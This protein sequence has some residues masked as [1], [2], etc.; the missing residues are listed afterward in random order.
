M[1]F[2]ILNKSPPFGAELIASASKMPTYK[3]TMEIVSAKKAILQLFQTNQ[4]YVHENAPGKD[5][6]LIV[7]DSNN[8]EVLYID[9]A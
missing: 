5:V 1:Y 7:G 8:R 4:N 2:Q 6:I 9:N 3:I